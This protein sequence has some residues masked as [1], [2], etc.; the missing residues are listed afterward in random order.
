MPARS[1]LG[2]KEPTLPAQYTSSADFTSRN[3]GSVDVTVGG[4]S[5]WSLRKY[6]QRPA[7]AAHRTLQR[8]LRRF[9]FPP[10]RFRARHRPS[11]PR[12]PAA[13]GAGTVTVTSPGEIVL[14]FGS[15]ISSS[16]SGA[17]AA[18]SVSIGSA[19]SKATSIQ[20]LEG[21]SIETS[22]TTARRR[23][24]FRSSPPTSSSTA[25]ARRSPVRTRRRP[26]GRRG[27]TP[28]PHRSHHHL[29]WRGD[30]H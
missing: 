11:P 23:A 3:A 4:A 21:S 5:R 1:T 29:Q 20:V 6:P 8:R 25:K 14:Q 27:S 19:V 30:N 7:P 9:L 16:A 12:H 28:D 2:P 22:S 26:A 18:G 13:R 10:H 17:G 24:R 15:E